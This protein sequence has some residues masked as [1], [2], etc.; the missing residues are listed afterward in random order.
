MGRDCLKMPTLKEIQTY[1]G[2]K[3]IAEIGYNLKLKEYVIAFRPN[4][5]SKNVTC[6]W[7]EEFGEATE[8]KVYKE[9]IID[10]IISQL[11]K[12]K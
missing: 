8:F 5:Y 6:S 2:E 11:N 4:D 12:H 9:R 7:D 10:P 1:L 3:I